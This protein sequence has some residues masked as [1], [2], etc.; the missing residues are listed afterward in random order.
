M[1]TGEI[2]DQGYD[3]LNGGDR[4]LGN[5]QPQLGA[6]GTV[7]WFCLPHVEVRADVFS[8]QDEGTTILG[9]LHV[10]L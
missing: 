3:T 1:A 2:L 10:F 5:G 7:D 4:V 6:W 8:R 9:Q